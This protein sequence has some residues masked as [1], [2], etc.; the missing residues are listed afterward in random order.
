MVDAEVSSAGAGAAGTR[1]CG[2]SMLECVD[3]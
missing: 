3:V 2:C 1:M